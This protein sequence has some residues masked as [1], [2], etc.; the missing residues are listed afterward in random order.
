MMDKFEYLFINFTINNIR[1][2]ILLMDF[3]LNLK[4][5]Q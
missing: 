2:G 4:I 3:S 1:E 5:N